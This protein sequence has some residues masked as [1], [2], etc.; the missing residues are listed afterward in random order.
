M[1]TDKDLQTT[2]D[3]VVTGDVIT[4]P[5]WPN[6]PT[7]LPGPRVTQPPPGQRRSPTRTDQVIEIGY[8]QETGEPAI[9]HPDRSLPDQSQQGRVSPDLE[10]D[11]PR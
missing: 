5:R 10:K 3:S 8:N 1:D 9:Y 4:H 2:A 11:M 7:S 6:W